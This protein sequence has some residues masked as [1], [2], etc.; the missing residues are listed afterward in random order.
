VAALT[1]AVLPMIAGACAQPPAERSPGAS[2]PSE[3]AW[4]LKQ[5]MRKLWTDHVAWTRNYVIAAVAGAPDAAEAAK[6][7]MNNQEAIGKAVAKYYGDPAGDQLTALLKEHISIAVDV[8][9]AAKLKDK[10]AF[11][12]ADEKWHANA[13]RIADFLSAANPHWPKATLTSLMKEHLSTTTD[14]VSARI[15]KDWSADVKAYDSIYEHIL[16]LSDALADGIVK[17][18]P[19]KFGMPVHN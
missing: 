8:V 1:V 13:D 11:K 4:I 19:A 6:R 10:A 2:A 16:K 15:K 5:D 12:R 7:L 14:E 9:K 18:F 3:A 17:Q